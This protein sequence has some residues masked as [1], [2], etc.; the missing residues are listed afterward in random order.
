MSRLPKDINS[1]RL[2][3]EL[4]LVGLVVFGIILWRFLSWL[5][6]QPISTSSD[7]DQIYKNLYNTVLAYDFSKG[8]DEDL[9]KRMERAIEGNSTSSQL[10]YNLKARIEYNHRLQ[11][12]GEVR[13][14]ID[15]VE[16]YIPDEEERTYIQNILLSLPN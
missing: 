3:I 8:R 14:D 15:R 6:V 9:E 12:Y 5:F 10:Y 2:K 13:E 11:R 16:D 1:R 7:H 4:L